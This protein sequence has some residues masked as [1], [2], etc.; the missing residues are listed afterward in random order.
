MDELREVPGQRRSEKA[1]RVAHARALMTRLREEQPALR[2]LIAGAEQAFLDAEVAHDWTGQQI[3]TTGA[4]K[5][6]ACWIAGVKLASTVIAGY[7]AGASNA[8]EAQSFKRLFLEITEAAAEDAFDAHLVDCIV[9]PPGWS[10]HDVANRFA[11]DVWNASKREVRLH[12]KQVRLGANQTSPDTP[13]QVIEAHGTASAAHPKKRRRPPHPEPETLLAGKTAVTFGTAA[14]VL[15]MTERRVRA[16]VEEQK[17]KSLGA[18]HSKKIEVSSLRKYAGLFEIR[19]NP[20][21]RGT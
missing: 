11:R 9:C 5:Q 1:Y 16:L 6:P 4:G 14:E 15:G 7:A 17:L 21:Q 18:G 13:A 10:L 20:E 19:N 8:V 2:Q 3:D 12:L